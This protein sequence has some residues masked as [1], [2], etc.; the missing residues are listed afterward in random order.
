MTPIPGPGRDDRPLLWRLWWRLAFTPFCRVVGLLPIS[1]WRDE[2]I[3]T[4]VDI[5]AMDHIGRIRLPWEVT[6]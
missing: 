3:V 4:R 1:E 6:R 2:A 5:W